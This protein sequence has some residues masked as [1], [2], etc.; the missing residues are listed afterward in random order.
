MVLLSVVEFERKMSDLYHQKCQD[1]RLRVTQG[2]WKGPIVPYIIPKHISSYEE[3]IK[4]LNIALPKC[5][6]PKNHC[7]SDSLQFA[8][9]GRPENLKNVFQE[10]TFDVFFFLSP[11]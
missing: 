1:V 11:L 5:I 7:V 10:G 3:V 4:I 8:P 9:E 6:W 2:S